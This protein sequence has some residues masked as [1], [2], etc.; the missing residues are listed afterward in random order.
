MESKIIGAIIGLVLALYVA[1][2][3]LPNAISTMTAINAS[4]ASGYGF[5][6]T[7]VTSLWALIPLFAVIALLLLVY[8]HIKE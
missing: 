7:S 4:S 6:G 3:T 5:W 8:N 1:T 2:A